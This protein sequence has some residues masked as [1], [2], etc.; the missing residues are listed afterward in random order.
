MET[1][2]R[3]PLGMNSCP[4]ASNRTATLRVRARHKTASNSHNNERLSRHA[5]EPLTVLASTAQCGMV[6][7]ADNTRAIVGTRRTIS[8]PSTLDLLDEDFPEDGLPVVH[9]VLLVRSIPARPDRQL[10]G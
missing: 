3:Q 8:P 5:A 4:T 1:C 6:H 2:E 7:I 10:F 9:R